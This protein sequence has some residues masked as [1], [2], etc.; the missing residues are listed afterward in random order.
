MSQFT[1]K[2]HQES[3]LGSVERYF[4]DCQQMGNADYA[5]QKTTRELW[6]SKSDFTPLSGFP[7]EMPYFCLRVR[8]EAGT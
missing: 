8:L 7:S 4:R 5:F 2:K 3:A 6:G 1:P